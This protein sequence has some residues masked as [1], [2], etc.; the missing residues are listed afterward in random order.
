MPSLVCVRLNE[1]VIRRG[2]ALDTVNSP[3]YVPQAFV[4]PVLPDEIPHRRSHLSV[5]IQHRP[6]EVER[7]AV[8]IFGQVA[9]VA[10]LS[11]RKLSAEN[12]QQED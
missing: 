11:E 9:L 1:Q 5:P 6:I 8:V 3:S 12:E 2:V 10:V 4:S 7:A